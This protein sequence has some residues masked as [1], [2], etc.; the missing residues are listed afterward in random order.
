MVEQHIQVGTESATQ[1]YLRF[2]E[3]WR[4]GEQDLKSEPA[5]HLNFENLSMLLSVLTP[6]RLKLL[7]ELR[8]NGPASIRALAKLL[9]RDYKNVHTDVRSLESVGLIERNTQGKVLVPWDVID[10]HV[11]LVA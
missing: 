11:A 2:I 10:A 6:Q 1:G 9:S 5:I 7:Q 3:A 8:Q 4:S